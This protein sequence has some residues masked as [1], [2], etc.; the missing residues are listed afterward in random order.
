MFTV[1]DV[2]ALDLC[3]RIADE[4]CDNGEHFAGVDSET[5]AVEC[6][7]THAVRVE[8]ASIRIASAGIASSGVSA[9]AS[10]TIAHGLCDGVTRVRCYGCGYGVRFPDVHLGAA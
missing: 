4:L 8:V 9:S 1:L 3:E 6:C 10:V 7:N 5:F 2:E